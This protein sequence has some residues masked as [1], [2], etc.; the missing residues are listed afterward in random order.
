MPDWGKISG[1]YEIISGFLSGVLVLTGLLTW[2][3]FQFAW[4]F[5]APVLII[6]GVLSFFDD[7]FP[8]GRQ[9]HL[10]SESGGFI[11]GCIIAGL[12]FIYGFTAW[13]LSLVILFEAIKYGY[14]VLRK[15]GKR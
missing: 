15:I 10:M 14:K 3:V 4:S 9:P 13:L 2:T 8:Y 7:I 6:I 11:A 12:S 1:E 5:A